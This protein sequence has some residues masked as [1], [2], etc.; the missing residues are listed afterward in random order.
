MIGSAEVTRDGSA[1]TRSRADSLRFGA[2]LAAMGAVAG[3]AYAVS[4]WAHPHRPAILALFAAAV[5]IGHLPLL[6]GA[7]RIVSSALREPFFIG[8]SAL[9]VAVIAVIV[10]LD[11]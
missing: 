5:A 8:W 7:E 9:T 6:A 4:T 11:G 1:G 10:G 2:R 3:S